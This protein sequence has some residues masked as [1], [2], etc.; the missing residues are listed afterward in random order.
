MNKDNEQL[1]SS[2]SDEPPDER[3]FKL[4]KK[5]DRETTDVRHDSTNTT[6]PLEKENDL[7]NVL[8]CRGASDSSDVEKKE[9]QLCGGAG[10]P[11]IENV[12]ATSFWPDP[13]TSGD[14]YGSSV[15]KK[16]R[17]IIICDE[18]ATPEKSE[19]GLQQNIAEDPEAIKVQKN[20]KKKRK[21][22]LSK[23]SSTASLV[24]S[25]DSVSARRKKKKRRSSLLLMSRKMKYRQTK[26][27]CASYFEAPVWVKENSTT[28]QP[29]NS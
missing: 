24:Q 17:E 3:G 1:L 21:E 18:G 10:A 16:K 13:A 2:P 28:S 15:K 8:A 19:Q 11:C 27:K 29:V 23:A 12:L 7:E 4:K 22:K 5:K 26:T 25:D 9:K 20:R 6:L 14:E